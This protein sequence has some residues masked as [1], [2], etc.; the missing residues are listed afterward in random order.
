MKSS[1]PILL[2]EDD[3]NDA[4]T[5][6]RAFKELK[7]TNELVHTIDG[8]EALEYLKDNEK[9]KPCLILLDLNMPKMNGMDFLKHAKS[10]DD[11]KDISVVVLTT[12]GDPKDIDDTFNQNVAG[13][14]VKPVDYQKF[15][16]A[17][18]A[19]NK[20]WTLSEL[21]NPT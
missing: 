4:M 3:T 16:E 21:P 6:K 9:K 17:V 18:N 5:I 11:L 20:Y 8:I 14:I 19:I 10:D 12:S 2:V 15:L 7:I 1:K 13:Y